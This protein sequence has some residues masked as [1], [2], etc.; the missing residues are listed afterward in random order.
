[1]VGG[2]SPPFELC[3]RIAPFLS[4]P[5]FHYYLLLHLLFAN[6]VLC[7]LAYPTSPPYPP[8]QNK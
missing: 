5:F 6:D 7:W 4:L 3:C 1:M 2:L 8:R